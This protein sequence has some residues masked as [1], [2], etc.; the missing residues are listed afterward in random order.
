MTFAEFI[1]SK[2]TRAFAEKIGAEYATVRMWISR[3]HISRSRWPDLLHLYPELG[4]SDLLAMEHA[5][6]K[7]RADT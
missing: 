5:S 4:L 3:N 2:G 6:E 7:T 1:K